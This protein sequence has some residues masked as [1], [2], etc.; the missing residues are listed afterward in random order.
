MIPR[1]ARKG[2]EETGKGELKIKV[3]SPPSKGEANR[4]AVK[5]L[6]DFFALP[7]SRINIVRGRTSRLKLISLKVEEEK[8]ASLER[9]DYILKG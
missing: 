2:I 3:K 6:S 5:L 1:A 9:K 8:F 7:S 4:E